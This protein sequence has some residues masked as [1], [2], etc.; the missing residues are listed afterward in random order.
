MMKKIGLLMCVG[1]PLWMGSPASAQSG[2]GSSFSD[3]G[4]KRLEAGTSEVVYTEKFFMGPQSVWEIDGDIYIYS[5]QIWI[6]PTAQIKGKGKLILKNPGS[7]PYYSDWKNQPSFM[8]ANGGNHI[9][10]NIIIDNNS[11]LQLSNIADPGY[12]LPI[13]E[14]SRADLK[15][16]GNIDFNARGGNIILDGHSLYLGSSSQLLNAGVLNNPGQYARG[17]VVTSNKPESMLIKSMQEGEKF[18][19]PV[20][21]AENSYTPAILSPANKVEMQVGVVDYAQSGLWI[22]DP[23]M[24][25]DR[26]WKILAD[27][28]TRADYTLVH[29]TISNGQAY[30]DEH[31]EIMQYSSGNNW[32]GD[33]TKLESEGVH[34]RLDMLVS[35]VQDAES[36]WA[37]KFTLSGLVAHDDYF[38]LAYAD[39]YEF[40]ENVFN[41]LLNDIPGNSPID[42]GS[43][44]IIR[45]PLNG[46]VVVNP[47]GTVTYTPYNGSIGEDTFE[48]RV[49]DKRGK[50]STATVTINVTARDLHIP[51]VFTPN[52]DGYNDVFEIIGYENYDRINLIVINRW[53]NEVFRM[54]KY[55]NR[56]D[57]QGLNEGT[58]YYIIEAIKG[59]NKRVFKG[60]VLIK[61]N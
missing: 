30:V 11:N 53:G 48:Y 44:E 6:A 47:D 23:Q 28:A 58:Y 27:Q 40:N 56:W 14:T 50:T 36:V 32:I 49:A 1:L 41:I 60:D 17:F 55:D 33:V 37:T 21:T 8:D 43:V 2:K 20:G 4:Y 38:E 9:G 31:A 35:A 15:V 7:N 39:K 42:V 5:Q 52:G 18:L 25:M 22:E 45:R 10:V 16:G 26:V 29:Q 46:T 57:G 51:N 3:N 13:Q 54:A 59:N 34:T 24:G 19:F 61:R 12:N